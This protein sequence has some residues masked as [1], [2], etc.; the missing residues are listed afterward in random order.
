ML[1]DFVRCG[2][3]LFAIVRLLFFARCVML[4]IVG[5][6]C[7]TLVFAVVSCWLLFAVVCCL[8]FAVVGCWL[9]VVFVCSFVLLLCVIV[10]CLLFE[11]VWCSLFA[12]V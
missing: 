10:C 9:L 6:R 11:I 5:C 3:L 2:S 1:P 7:C 12:V 8:W 4:H